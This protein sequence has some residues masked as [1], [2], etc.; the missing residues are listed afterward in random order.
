MIC[1]KEVFHA[2]AARAFAV[3]ERLFW[4]RSNTRPSVLAQIDGLLQSLLPFVHDAPRMSAQGE[5][6][7]AECALRHVWINILRSIAGSD[8]KRSVDVL[9]LHAAQ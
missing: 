6:D 4:T 5:C 1:L 3:A 2:R 7:R 9:H 8:T